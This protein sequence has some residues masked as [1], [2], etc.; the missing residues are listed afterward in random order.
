[1]TS[2]ELSNTGRSAS[3]PAE[4]CHVTSWIIA[5]RSLARRPAFALIAVLT[6]AFGIGATTAIFSVV[7]TVLI[8]PLPFPNA[9]RLVSVM[10]ANPAK[11]QSLS[12]VAPGRLEDWHGANRAF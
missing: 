6:L 8:R 1:M 3:N 4:E 5:C 7:D 11:A 9:D 10:E 12:L 2:Q